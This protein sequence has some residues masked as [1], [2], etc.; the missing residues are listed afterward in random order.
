MLS[1][2]TAFAVCL[3][4]A[5]GATILGARAEAATGVAFPCRVEMFPAGYSK[6]FGFGN[7]GMVKIEFWTQPE[8]GGTSCGVGYFYSAGATRFPSATAASYGHSE[9]SLMAQFQALVT[10]A[11]TAQRVQFITESAMYYPMIY[12]ARI[13]TSEPSPQ[14]TNCSTGGMILFQ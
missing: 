8:C 10:A 14:S 5:F 11:S 9:A 6:N 4:A 3:F 13:A 12:Q 2:R 7:Y 1:L